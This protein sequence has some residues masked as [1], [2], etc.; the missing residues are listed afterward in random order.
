ME[1]L[2]GNDLSLD[3]TDGLSDDFLGH[4]LKDHETL[5][6]DH[7]V[8]TAADQNVLL[9]DED[10]VELAV[11]EV[12]AAIE[13]IKA[14]QGLVSAPFVEGGEVTVITASSQADVAGDGSSKS[15]SSSQGGNA[16]S[17]KVGE[18]GVVMDV[19]E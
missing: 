11:G 1:L 5:L 17:E 15:G 14:V 2:K 10:L 4:L 16:K 12:L 3:L 7:D 13:V 18:H 6:N 9:L 8:D 19:E